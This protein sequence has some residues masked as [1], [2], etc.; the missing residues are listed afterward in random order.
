[1][2]IAKTETGSPV[3]A[4]EEKG[5]NLAE[6]LVIARY[7]MFSQVY[8]HRVRR[9]YDYHI[10]RAAK[11]VLEKNGLQGV[12]PPP[13]QINDYLSFDDWKIN[14]ALHEGLGDKHGEIILTRKH[15]KCIDKTP[16]NPSEKEEQKIKAKAQEWEA[17]GVEVY[18]DEASTSWYKLDKDIFI[19]E[20]DLAQPLSEKS[21][22]QRLYVE[23]T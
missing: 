18:L 8:F 9:V 2:T 20:N 3:L 1:M 15:F 17:K 13:T 14:A 4:I 16:D 19:E 21:R 10:Y 23:Q 6:N 22:L 11:C 7:Q 5:W 12:Y